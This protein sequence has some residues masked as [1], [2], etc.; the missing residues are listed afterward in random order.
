[1]F[2]KLGRRMREGLLYQGIRFFRLRDSEDRSARG[3]AI[4]L[5][6]NFYPTFGLGGFIAIFFARLLGG[7]MAAAFIGGSILAVIWPVLFYLNIQVGSLFL[8][9]VVPVEDL[10]DVTPQTVDALVW[11]QTFAIGSVIN[12]LIVGLVGYFIFLALYVRVRPV[13]LAWL[14]GRLRQ[15]N[16][17]RF[18]EAKEDHV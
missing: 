5:A 2:S 18:L 11:G 8:R 1:M 14:R 7:N 10:E 15:R 6:C 17:L 9:P 4:G 13:A 12:S 16:T 3:F